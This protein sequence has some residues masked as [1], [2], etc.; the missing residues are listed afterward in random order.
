MVT[1]NHVILHSMIQINPNPPRLSRKLAL[2]FWARVQTGNP[3]VCWPWK[4][5][6][7]KSGYG[8]LSYGG[9]ERLAHRIA[10]FLLTGYWP[11]LGVSHE[12]DN[13]PCCNPYHLLP[14][15]HEE[16][17]RDASRKGRLHN[18]P[19][20]GRRGELNPSAKLTVAAV[21]DI[22]NRHQNGV[23]RRTL[24]REYKVADNA[25]TQVVKGIT[26]TSV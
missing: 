25:I 7:N 6:T 19:R 11:L 15:T 14:A 23:S 10:F 18:K 2:D 26:W 9:Q 5:R 3:N 22:R 1:L 8:T 24:A 12:C 4:G 13:P 16:N 20:P 21:H 17:M